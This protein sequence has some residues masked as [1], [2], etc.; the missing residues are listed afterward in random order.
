MSS[1]HPVFTPSLIGTLI[2]FVVFIFASCVSYGI[3]IVANYA[4]GLVYNA[5]FTFSYGPYMHHSVSSNTYLG[6]LVQGALTGGLALSATGS[7]HPRASTR[8]IAIVTSFL[9]LCLF[10]SQVIQWQESGR[11][12]GGT[13]LWDTLFFLGWVGSL[14]VVAYAWKNRRQPLAH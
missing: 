11:E 2:G 8:A 7:I 12:F 13:I 14:L 4:C 5:A 9:L 3:G 10:G 1:D 6:L